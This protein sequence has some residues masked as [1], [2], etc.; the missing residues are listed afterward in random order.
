MIPSYRVLACSALF[1]GSLS[2]GSLAAV[3][4]G[5]RGLGGPGF[6]GG[7]GPGKVV[8][9]EPFTAASTSTSIDKL[10]DGTTITH[11]S[12]STEARDA[13]GRTEHAT[14]TTGTNGPV[15]RT[16]V[17]DPVAHTITDWSSTS[18]VATQITLPTNPPGGRGGWGGPG[19]GGPGAGGPPPGGPGGRPGRVKPQVV[20]VDLTPKII[21]GVNA[22]GTKTTITIPAGAEGNDKPLV[23]TREVWKSTALGIVLLEISDS[24]REGFHKMEVTSLT[25]G[26][27]DSSLFAVPQGYTVKQQTRHGR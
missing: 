21:A 16:S 7:F 20:T 24:P 15:T 12:T 19:P 17:F 6:G 26:T 5:P 3:A 14:T 22:T 13:D 11:N 27:P 2:F 9:G 23:S 1:F 8:T 4:Q 18:T 25:Q 10:A